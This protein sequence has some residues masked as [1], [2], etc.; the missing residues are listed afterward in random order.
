ML[1]KLSFY[2]NFD[3]PWC[4]MVSIDFVNDSQQIKFVEKCTDWDLLMEN[5]RF[6]LDEPYAHCKQGN[7]LFPIHAIRVIRGIILPQVSR[8]DY[9]IDCLHKGIHLSS[10]VIYKNISFALNF[11]R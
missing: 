1:P 8:L 2:Q 9:F 11:L 4:T 5:P 3:R 10:S 6:N 7:N